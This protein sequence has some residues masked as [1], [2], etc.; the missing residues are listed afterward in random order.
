MGNVAYTLDTLC[1]EKI[2][3]ASQGGWREELS[4]W[5]YR[6]LFVPVNIKVMSVTFNSQSDMPE[7][8]MAQVL[9]VMG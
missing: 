6:F 7:V 3:K 1:S 4:C 9:A 5:W 8:N 2:H